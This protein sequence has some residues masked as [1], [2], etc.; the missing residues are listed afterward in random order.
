MKDLDIYEMEYSVSP[1]GVD[2]WEIQERG[3]EFFQGDFDTAE[4]AISFALLEFEGQELNLNIKNVQAVHSEERRQVKEG[5][6]EKTNAILNEYKD[7]VRRF[8][9]LYD[10]ID[11]EDADLINEAGVDKWFKHAFT[12]SLDELWFEA[13]NWELTKEDLKMEGSNE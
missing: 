1:G 5:I 3:G 4:D 13:G 9:D 8:W 10:E 11:Q 2:K 12:L 6:L 7:L